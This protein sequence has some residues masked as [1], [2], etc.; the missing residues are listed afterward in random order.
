[1]AMRQRKTRGPSGPATLAVMKDGRL[2]ITLK[3]TGNVL[4]VFEEDNEDIFAIVKSLGRCELNVRMNLEKTKILSA[5]PPGNKS[6]IARFI[7]FVAKEGQ[8]PVPEVRQERQGLKKDG[9]PFTIPTHL[10]MYAL[11]EV[12]HDKFKGLQIVGDIAYPFVKAEKDDT[13]DIQGFGMKKTVEFMQVCGFDME[14]DTIAW[15]DNVLPAIEDIL[16]RRNRAITI[17][18][19][20]KGFIKEFDDIPDGIKIDMPKGKVRPPTDTESTKK[21]TRK[22]TKKAESADELPEL[23]R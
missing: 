14:N 13:T 1:M 19:D 2:R 8:L 4:E 3:E 18:L 9:H 11:F 6:Y 16:L 7:G 15:S 5:T 12:V 23:D 22:S 10:G 21:T 17:K 20:E